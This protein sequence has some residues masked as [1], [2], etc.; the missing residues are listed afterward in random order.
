MRRLGWAPGSITV[1]QRYARQNPELFKKFAEEFVTLP[2]D[3][4]VTVGAPATAAA[5]H[6]T[7]SI[8]IVMFNEGDP[9][10]SGLIS[11]LAQPAGNVTGFSVIE[12]EL[13]ARR[14]AVLRDLLPNVHAVA[15]LVYRG[16]R[17][18]R[19]THEEQ[20]ADERVYRLFDM[21]P[22][23]F[24]ID[25]EA[26]VER[27]VNQAVREGAGALV[28]PGELGDYAGTI[29][30]VAIRNRLASI[31]SDPGS[32][33]AGILLSL[34]PDPNEFF[35][36]QAYFVDKI[37]KGS[38]PADLPVRQPSRF[39][40]YINTKTGKALGVRIPQSILLKAT[41]FV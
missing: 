11:S 7:S 1:E 28:V 26:D 13:R 31:T 27:A 35:E 8:P 38:K 6:A 29:A 18:E 41:R 17:R 30:G 15:V 9:V 34:S 32:V 20:S 24:N 12:E 36:V 3:V 10:A 37:L 16:M 33:E 5:V 40:M 22:V 19:R 14:L 25:R 4:I 21:R 39:E 23:F 2:V